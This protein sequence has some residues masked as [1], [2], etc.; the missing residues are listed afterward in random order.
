ML[1]GCETVGSLSQPAQQ[2]TVESDHK[3]PPADMIE[4]AALRYGIPSKLLLAVAMVESGCFPYSVNTSGRA[5]RFSSEA[6]VVRFVEGEVRRGNRNMSVGC[7]QL[8]YQTH[9][10]Y[11]ASVADMVN[12]E[13][14][15]LY[16]ASLLRTLHDRYGSW[17]KAVKMYHSGRIKYNSRYYKK[18]MEQ[19]G[20][21]KRLLAG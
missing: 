4:R 12:Y 5:I 14:N 1:I 21:D 7:M 18:V 19:Y 2:G 13:K 9:G 3:A 20:G 16:A 8:H 15:I 11:F 6:E 10:R 17:E